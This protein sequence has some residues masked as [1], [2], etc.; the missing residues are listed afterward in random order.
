MPEEGDHK[1]KIEVNGCQCVR[2]Y[3]F[4]LG[5]ICNYT[6]IMLVSTEL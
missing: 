1:R 5:Q 3:A 4:F 6:H 2:I